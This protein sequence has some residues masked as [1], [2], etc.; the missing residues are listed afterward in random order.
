MHYKIYCY[1][2]LI[3]A[4][5]S[6][7]TERVPELSPGIWR[8]ELNIQDQQLPFNF[9]L[10]Q[11]GEMYKAY[12]HNAEERLLLDE[13]NIAGDSVS[14]AMHI[15]DADIKA[16]IEGDQLTGYWK[17][18]YVKDYLIPFRA[19]LHQPHRFA[20]QYA[21]PTA[22]VG[23]WAVSLFHKEDT[24]QAVAI[25][26]NQGEKVVGTFLTP[27]GDY[28]YLEGGVT[29]GKLHLSAFDG[30]HAFLFTA[31]A[32]ENGTLRGDFWSGKSWHETW[33]AVKDGK[34]SLPVADALTYLKEGYDHI[35]FKFPDLNGDTLSPFHP[36]FK[37]K[38]LILQIFGT[39]CPNC[40]DETKFLSQWYKNNRERG[41]EILGLAYEAKDDFTYA[42]ARILKMKEKLGVDY[43]FVVAG[44]NDKAQASQ[45]LP[46]LNHVMAFPTTIYL[47]PNKNLVK[48]HTG[49]T[50]PGTG[51]YYEQFVK[52]FNATVDKMLEE[53]ITAAK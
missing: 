51:P 5:V 44:L 41:V 14:I 32:T 28:R 34:A 23:R 9:E 39:W 4:V 31:K 27:T 22:F 53:G 43:D 36:R 46:M 38:A 15:F 21:D 30:G 40:M 49:F 47:D 12:L 33:M 52:E 19:R 29:L 2:L 45:T 13:I 7:N 18:N 10:I 16:K 6:C 11:D 24:S 25:F 42:K 48:I 50:G 26:K 35:D 1:G 20:H 37:D 3:M 17:K 8:G